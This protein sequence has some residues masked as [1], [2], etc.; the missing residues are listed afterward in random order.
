MFFNDFQFFPWLLAPDSGPSHW[1]GNLRKA[2]RGWRC[3]LTGN[4]IST[5]PLWQRIRHG[6]IVSVV[7]VSLIG[8]S[9]FHWGPH[10]TSKLMSLRS[11]HHLR[12]CCWAS[13]R[14][15]KSHLRVRF[16]R[17]Q[18]Y[19]STI[20]DPSSAFQ[21]VSESKYDL[22][23]TFVWPSYLRTFCSCN[24]SQLSFAALSGALRVQH[25]NPKL[26][27]AWNSQWIPRIS[28]MI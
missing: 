12:H 19:S 11:L 3:I 14:F 13:C 24:T 1:H 17:P 6:Q 18:L 15:P 21:C 10:G 23:M 9:K 7:S 26:N 27:A 2:I 28:K 16:A 4:V 25:R 22:R 20:F 5:E 8:A